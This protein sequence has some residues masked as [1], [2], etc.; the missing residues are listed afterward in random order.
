M[1]E[2]FAYLGALL[3]SLGGLAYLDKRYKLVFWQNFEAAARVLVI[4]VL[5]FVFWDLQG[6]TNGIFFEGSTQYLTGI[7]LAPELPLEEIFFL[8][9]LC[10][11]P[12]LAWEI[13]ERRRGR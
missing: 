6:I 13:L 12:L 4:G 10:Y 9:L 7:R 8:T 2:H 3:F 1:L 5:F 11:T